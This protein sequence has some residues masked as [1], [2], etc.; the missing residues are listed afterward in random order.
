MAL[1]K[2]QLNKLSKED[3][4]AYALIIQTNQEKHI[5]EMIEKL[6]SALE[7]ITFL[8]DRQEILEA[9]LAVSKTSNENV[10]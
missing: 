7:K 10:L 8:S 9:T 6:D 4:I 3:I 2:T 5:D 1:T